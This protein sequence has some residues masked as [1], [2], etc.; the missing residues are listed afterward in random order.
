MDDDERMARELAAQFQEEDVASGSPGSKPLTT[1]QPHPAAGVGLERSP[2]PPTHSQPKVSWGGADSAWPPTASAGSAAVAGSPAGWGDDP[3]GSGQGAASADPWGMPAPDLQQKQQQEEEEARQ[4]QQRAAAD[5]EL[6][7]VQAEEA[8]KRVEEVSAQKAQWSEEQRM[9]MQEQLRLEREEQL[10]IEREKKEQAKLQMEQQRAQM[11][12]ESKKRRMQDAKITLES[13]LN[14]SMSK[15]PSV[16]EWALSEARR[17][18]LAET[19]PGLLRAAEEKL[20]TTREA[21]RRVAATAR[22]ERAVAVA[23]TAAVEGDSTGRSIQALRGAL[24]QAKS[25][26]LHGTDLYQAE[27][28]LQEEEA[29]HISSETSQQREQRVRAE[30]ESAQQARKTELH[31]LQEAC[32]SRDPE[33]IENAISRAVVLPQPLLKKA[34]DQVKALHFYARSFRPPPDGGELIREW[35]AAA[36]AIQVAREALRADLNRGAAAEDLERSLRVAL[37]ADVDEQACDEAKRTAALRNEA[38]DLAACALVARDAA[39]LR[40]ALAANEAA[41]GPA[42]DVAPLRRLLERFAAGEAVPASS[43]S[44]PRS[45]AALQAPLQAIPAPVPASSS[46]LPPSAAALPG[47]ALTSGSLE[48]RGSLGG[49]AERWA[50]ARAPNAVDRF[51]DVRGRS[52]ATPPASSLLESSRAPHVE[53]SREMHKPSPE[54]TATEEE[55]EVQWEGVYSAVKSRVERARQWFASIDPASS[56]TGP[57]QVAAVDW[58]P[59]SPSGQRG[60]QMHDIPFPSSPDQ[61]MCGWNP[62]RMWQGSEPHAPPVVFG[63]SAPPSPGACGQS[64]GAYVPSERVGYVPSH[65]SLSGPAGFSGAA[66]G[67]GASFAEPRGIAS[68]ML[69]EM[70]AFSGAMPSAWAPASQRSPSPLGAHGGGPFHSSASLGH[71]YQGAGY[72][73]PASSLLDGPPASG[74]F[75]SYG[76]YAG[77]M[78]GS[79]PNMGTATPYADFGSG[80]VPSSAP[81]GGIDYKQFVHQHGSTRRFYEQPNFWR[82]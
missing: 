66:V 2:P 58:R 12:E 61:P 48:S 9:R 21:E 34:R 6:R 26:G 55:E 50:A 5:E 16:V 75:G 65:S 11:E 32:S 24:D 42:E 78:L 7:R 49:S 28:V 53:A 79:M 29:K 72:S 27:K 37:D 18:G 33:Q 68:A 63:H 59:P 62:L 54:R 4:P 1:K 23:A 76:G 47:P 73:L 57:A 45:T 8:S 31:A 14:P 71:G 40:H 15:D 30:Q 36:G 38:H 17:A 20:G 80:R 60:A 67:S 13:A 52:G 39:G 81:V 22:L 41:G 69:P 51:F 19:E 77:G 74:P 64:P 56:S 10:R 46:S 25:A 82:F 3:W 70:P 43:Y 44:M 35:A